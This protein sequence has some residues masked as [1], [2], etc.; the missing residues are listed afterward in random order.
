MT[1]IANF[2]FLPMYVMYTVTFPAEKQQFQ[3]KSN[4]MVYARRSCLSSISLY[5][6]EEKFKKK[7]WKIKMKTMRFSRAVI[8]YSR[9]IE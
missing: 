4:K 6:F 5:K 3:K 2:W 1:A 9:D 7:T 8:Q